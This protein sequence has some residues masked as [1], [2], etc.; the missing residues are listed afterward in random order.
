[1]TLLSLHCCLFVFSL[2]LIGY[3]NGTATNECDSWESISKSIIEKDQLNVACTKNPICSGIRCDGEYKFEYNGD[4]SDVPISFT[5]EFHPCATP[6]Q[7]TFYLD[8]AWL[9][10]VFNYTFY[11]NQSQ[12]SFNQT[13]VNTTIEPYSV[14]AFIAG[15]FFVATVD[16]KQLINT[17]MNITITSIILSDRQTH[18]LVLIPR[19]AIPVPSCGGSNRSDPV[20]YIRR[21]APQ[22][23]YPP[24]Q[25]TGANCTVGSFESC[26]NNEVC[27][28]A[29]CWC[30][31]NYK[32]NSKKTCVPMGDKEDKEDST[33]SSVWLIVGSV[34]AGAV[35][36]GA[37]L[38]MIVYKYRRYQQRY[39]QH[40][41]LVADASDASEFDNPDP[42]MLEA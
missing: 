30:R 29:K 21:N 9:G 6:L 12:I 11:L 4:S 42:P 41:L 2:I 36:I 7:F 34:I 40:E 16:S 25:A 18:N 3:T 26:N 32:L 28:N 10:D 5:M 39:G 37:L 17:E 14:A 8:I 33:G 27:D 15:K 20:V 1:M 38:I 24:L 35:V 23:T 13:I 31:P 19:V 22:A